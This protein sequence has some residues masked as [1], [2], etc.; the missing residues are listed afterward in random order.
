[1]ARGKCPG[2]VFSVNLGHL[3]GVVAGILGLGSVLRIRRGYEAHH[4]LLL[5]L[6]GQAHPRFFT[7]PSRM[8]GPHHPYLKSPQRQLL[9][10]LQY[11]PW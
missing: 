4:S 2:L 5:L 7:E 6:A 8:A 11:P 3:S 10:T 9:W 1:M